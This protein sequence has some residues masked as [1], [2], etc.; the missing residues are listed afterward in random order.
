VPPDRTLDDIDL[1]ILELLQA[2]A[3][4]TQVEIAKAV[5]LAPSAVQ[6]RIRKLEARGVL[7]GYT[8][9]IDPRALDVGLLAFVAVRSDEAGSGNRIAQL[10]AE[11]SEVLEVHH[12]AGDDCYLIK[13]RSRDAEHLGQ[14]LRT[15]FARI[16]GVR[17]TRTTIV[18]ETVKETSR[19]PIVKREEARA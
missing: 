17:S 6:E 2:N 19:L 12:V 15:R 9:Q 7:R 10:L 11:H 1:R 4:E 18:L 8:I 3:R 14:L 13:V 16:P 5:G